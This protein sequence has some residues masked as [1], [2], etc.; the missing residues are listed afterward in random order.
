V[1]LAAA[2]LA[3]LIVV[4]VVAVARPAPAWDPHA[5]RS[6]GDWREWLSEWLTPA[7]DY[8][9]IA[10][11]CFDKTTHGFRAVPA[12]VSTVAPVDSTTPY[13]Y[14]KLSRAG[15]DAIVDFRPA[16]GDTSDMPVT[17]VKLRSSNASTTVVIP[18]A[19]GTLT[20]TCL[21]PTPACRVLGR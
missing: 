13:R 16:P 1:K 5:A 10:G 6:G 8:T 14:L 15:A 21:P 19:G 18:A 3:V 12:C 20:I 7:F 2:L 4:F 17:P 9:A 11:T